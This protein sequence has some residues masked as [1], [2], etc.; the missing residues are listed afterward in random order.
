MVKRKTSFFHFKLYQVKKDN[1]MSLMMISGKHV[2]WF[3]LGVYCSNG[4]QYSHA[5]SQFL[6]SVYIS[7]GRISTVD[8]SVHNLRKNKSGIDRQHLFLTRLS[9]EIVIKAKTKI[10]RMRKRRRRKKRRKNAI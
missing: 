1:G 2:F 7:R 8:V 5:K 6:F 10:D 4:N 9:L 3:W